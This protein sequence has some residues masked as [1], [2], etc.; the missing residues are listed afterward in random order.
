ML[1]ISP[2]LIQPVETVKLTLHMFNAEL[3]SFDIKSSFV[4]EPMQAHLAADW[5]YCDPLRLSQVIPNLSCITRS[6]C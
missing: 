5:V 4:V 1:E 6:I 3:Q 2:V